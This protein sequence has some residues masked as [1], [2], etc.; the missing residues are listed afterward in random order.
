MW[1][2]TSQKTSSRSQV[3]VMCDGESLVVDTVS[4][5]CV[6]GVTSEDKSIHNAG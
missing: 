3:V 5:T 1:G 2:K 6:M 4:V